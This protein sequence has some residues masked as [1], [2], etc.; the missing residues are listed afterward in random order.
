MLDGD[1]EALAALEQRV[2]AHLGF[3]R[4]LTSLASQRPTADHAMALKTDRRMRGS[5][6]PDDGSV[7]RPVPLSL[8]DAYSQ[9]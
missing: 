6:W 7:A 9:L 8:P 1:F 5:G 3:N 4:V 2:A